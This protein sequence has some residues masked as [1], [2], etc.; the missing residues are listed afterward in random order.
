MGY[1]TEYF[2]S[3][4]ITPVDRADLE[5]WLRESDFWCKH[6]D[7]IYDS[8][9]VLEE[10]HDAG[11]VQIVTHN[12]FDRFF[13]KPDFNDPAFRAELFSKIRETQCSFIYEMSQ[14]NIAP[15]D[16]SYDV[17]L[18]VL[19]R[20]HWMSFWIISPVGGRYP[21]CLWLKRA[22]PK[23]WLER[24]MQTRPGRRPKSAMENLPCWWQLKRVMQK[25]RNIGR[26]TPR[27]TPK[28]RE[29]V[30]ADWAMGLPYS[31]NA[32]VSLRAE[33]RANELECTFSTIGLTEPDISELVDNEG[34]QLAPPKPG[35]H[36]VYLCHAHMTDRRLF[37][38]RSVFRAAD[39]VLFSN[40][41]GTPVGPA[42]FDEADFV[43]VYPDKRTGELLGLQAGEST[44]ELVKGPIDQSEPFFCCW[45]FCV[46]DAFALRFE[47]DGIFNPLGR[48]VPL[49]PSGMMQFS[50]LVKSVDGD[51]ESVYWWRTVSKI[52]EARY[53]A[54]FAFCGDGRLLALDSFSADL[55]KCG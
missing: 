6:G 16:P 2:T 37:K 44:L 3:C 50:E 14:S 42:Q 52:S 8:F 9:W 31:S 5:S 27:L 36:S 55:R 7:E 41:S 29:N 13:P 51:P 17:I 24:V 45:T 48:G 46:P 1:H 19:T 39:V 25:M 40:T 35:F 26:D 10:G 4:P 53:V 33:T 30:L 43:E 28:D 23:P 32:V 34:L 12:T 11:T 22:V 20:D 21:E 15:D 38:S 54:F 47:Y 49:T 18:D